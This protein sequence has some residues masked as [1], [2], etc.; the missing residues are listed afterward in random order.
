MEKVISEENI[1]KKISEE[2]IGK[3]KINKQRNN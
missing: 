3:K 2:N 1:D